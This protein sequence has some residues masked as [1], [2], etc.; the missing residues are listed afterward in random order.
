[1]TSEFDYC[2]VG[3]GPAGLQLGYF[4]EKAG[5]S[6]VILE[7]GEAPGTFF[8]LHPRHRKL[9]SINKVYT[10]HCDADINYRW[11]WNAL[12]C[13]DERFLFRNY[14]RRYFPAADDL[15]RYLGEFAAH[16]GLDVRTGVNVEHVRRDGEHFLVV[17]ADGNQIRSRCL[18]VATGLAKPYIPEIPGIELVEQY[19]EVSVDPDDFTDQRVLIIGKGNSG[20]ETADNLVETTALIHVA[21]P[22]PVKFAWQSHFVGHLRAANNNLLDTYL[23]KCQN[24]TLEVEIEKIERV[25]ER[26]RVTVSYQRAMGSRDV[27]EYDRIIC[28]TG[29]RMD[30][31]IFDGDCRPN[32]VIDSRFPELDSSWQSTNVPGLYFAGALTQSRDFKKTASA[33]IHGFRY[34]VRALAFILLQRFHN[35]PLPQRALDCTAEALTHAIIDRV[36]RSSALW[37]QFSFLCDVIGVSAEGVEH[38]ESLPIDYVH[39]ELGQRFDTYFT[40]NL[41]YGFKPEDDPFRSHRV[42]HTDVDGA[43]D[44]TFLHP[45]VR[46]YQGGELQDEHHIVENLEANW[47]DEALHV[48]PLRAYLDDKLPRWI[49]EPA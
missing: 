45:V 43:R 17:D 13:D 1:M 30:T 22:R 25:N 37:Q 35:M 48:A 46:R 4:L 20:F 29:F 42:A 12:L 3:A 41:E 24:A 16:Y 49:A 9:I 32:T 26:F 38:Y 18:V 40:I 8:K 23:L 47:R 14:S 39:D 6:Y 27:I 44:S 19:E 15:V 28:C 31:D 5:K 7:R 21:S 34:N 11:D 2:I 36:N 10:G 33:F